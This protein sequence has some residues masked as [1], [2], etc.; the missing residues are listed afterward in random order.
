MNVLL[1]EWAGVVRGTVSYERRGR[2][3]YAVCRQVRNADRTVDDRAART[4]QQL[5]ARLARPQSFISKVLSRER[6]ISPDEMVEIASALHVEAQ[7]MFH[8]I[9]EGVQLDR[10]SAEHW[11]RRPPPG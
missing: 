8:A 4:Q 9:T 5:A 2:K 11:A 6:G 3:T 10:A 7:E 1:Q